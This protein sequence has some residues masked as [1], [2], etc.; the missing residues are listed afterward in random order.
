MV[1][2]RKKLTVEYPDPEEFD[3]VNTILRVRIPFYTQEEL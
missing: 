2:A 3:T 1:Q